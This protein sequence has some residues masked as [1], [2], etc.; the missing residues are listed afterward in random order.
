MKTIQRAPGFG[1]SK[2]LALGPIFFLLLS[3]CGSDGCSSDG[4]RDQAFPV[5]HVDKTV[6]VSAEVR[7]TSYGL[8]FMTG[9]VE[10]LIGEFTDDGLS[11]C[12]PKTTQNVTLVG[13]I[14][15]CAGEQCADGSEGCQL[16]LSIEDAQLVPQ[17]SNTLV[18]YI[19]IGDL[20]EEI[21]VKTSALS[22]D[23]LVYSASGGENVPATISA[24]VPIRI[25]VDTNSPFKDLRFVVEDIEIDLDDVG[26]KLKGSGFGGGMGCGAINIG[27]G[28]FDSTIKGLLLGEVEKIVDEMTTS[29]LCRQ[30]GSGE[31]ACPSNATC[32][33]D[34]VCMY[35]D[36]TC[37]PRFL[38]IEGVIEPDGL[39]GDYLATAASEVFMT[40]RL[41][42]RAVADT[43]VT[44]G[45]RVGTQPDGFTSCAPVDLATR[46]SL[47]PIPP[48][49]SLN[50]DVKPN[51]EPFMFGLA[52]HR[53]TL[54]HLMWSLWASGSLC[55]EVG[56]EQVD[57]LNTGLIAGL[58]KEIRD[59]AP[60]PGPL[61]M[62]ITP[63][64]A[65]DIRL[66]ANRVRTVDGEQEVDEGLLTLDWK[67]VDIHMDGFILERYVRLFTLRVDLEIPV[68]VLPDGDGGIY[69]VL[70][71]IGEGI[72]NMRLL[73]DNLVGG[74]VEDLAEIIPT[75]LG[76]AL[77]QIA[78]ALSDPIELPEFMGY[79]IVLAPDDLR[80][81]DNNEYLG[82]FANLEFVGDNLMAPNLLELRT[83]VLD[84]EVEVERTGEYLPQVQVKLDVGASLGGEMVAAEELQFVYSLNGG[85]W[86][87]GGVGGELTIRDAVLKAQGVHELELR[88]RKLEDGARWQR[89]PTVM[90]VIVDY[91]APTLE[92]WEV[93]DR[94]VVQASDL[95][96]PQEALEMRHRFVV[97]GI[98]QAWSMWA[99]IS[100]VELPQALRAER[101]AVEIQVRDQSGHIAEESL[102]VRQ[103]A[104]GADDNIEEGDDTQGCAA[105]G[106][107]AGGAA[108]FLLFILGVFALGARRRLRRAS[109]I[110]LL[111]GLVF[112]AGCKEDQSA[113][114]PCVGDE[115]EAP[116]CKADKECDIECGEGTFA[117][118]QDGSCVCESYCADGCADDRYCCFS[119]NSCKRFPDPCSEMT[120]NTGFEPAVTHIG[121]ADSQT[122][123]VTGATCE[124]VSLPPIPMGYFGAYASI[125]QGGA[126]DVIAIAAHNVLYR[127][128]M[129]GVVGKD[130]EAEWYFVDGI[131]S[132]GQ[133]RGDIEGPRRGVVTTGVKVGMYTAIAVD[134][135]G[136]IHVFYRDED[137]KS[138]KYARGERSG[139]EWSFETTVVEEGEGDT[140]YFSSMVRIDDTLHLFYSTWVN[141]TDSEIRHRAIAV[142]HP[143][144]EMDETAYQVIHTGSRG[145]DGVVDNKRLAGIHLQAVKTADGIF[146]S[147]FDNTIERASWIIGDGETFGAVQRFQMETGVYTSARPGPDGGVHVAFMDPEGPALSYALVGE[148]KEQIIT[149]V[150]HLMTG[151]S[152]APIGHD[153]QLEVFEDGRVELFYHDATTQELVHAK[154]DGGWQLETVAGVAGGVGPGHGLFVR[155][156]RLSDGQRLVMDFGVDTTGEERVGKPYLRI[157]D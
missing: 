140:G 67:D 92:L 30:C 54:Q 117:S 38:G 17:A 129:V 49:P 150:R 81:I 83:L 102:S 114:E 74:K 18:V 84:Q 98:R 101:L 132:R 113:D 55:L 72:K 90:D 149:G 96:D 27:A 119:S 12:V 25:E 56:T 4:F 124:C 115:C 26:Y 48:S 147:F 21:P 157:V 94:V 23:L 62:R 130:L 151:T 106:G 29:E 9:Q 75:L 32:S 99:E 1:W 41:A 123:E 138:L 20:L 143:V 47:A 14:D 80:G 7:V 133:V 93:E 53:R 135:A 19:E 37:V 39:L 141:E 103:S 142:D 43:G 44:I 60:N 59:L 33:S 35:S 120:C 112:T 57:M 10:N 79:R 146:L 136:R 105:I 6:P 73:N 85:P 69:P 104:L 66:G 70:G 139:Q 64:Q 65:P 77:P 89:I 153:V 87:L 16:D 24:H 5:E 110:A 36:N 131:P 40:A 76:F 145:S 22:C 34:E 118:C 122:C 45:A 3:A 121:D 71:D 11:F 107:G 116:V 2:Y 125:D 144:D 97:D 109:L 61:K 156:L 95:V 13:D 52:L 82:L 154:R 111:A 46:P 68:G 155:T 78:D 15:I 108:T 86:R 28:F 148:A 100:E 42:D 126:D 8:N 137:N 51:G 91:E 88:V 152:L 58:V 127:D 128:L 63:Q 50:V 31:P 134:D